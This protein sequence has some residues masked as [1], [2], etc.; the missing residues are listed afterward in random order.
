MHKYF[1]YFIRL[2]SVFIYP[3]FQALGKLISTRLSPGTAVSYGIE[4][5]RS[6][7]L[8]Q[9]RLLVEIAA[10]VYVIPLDVKPQ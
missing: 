1:L 7:M 3:Y 10:S 9:A 8:E 6:L 4:L 5:S 2:I